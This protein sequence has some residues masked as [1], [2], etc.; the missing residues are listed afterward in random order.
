[1]SGFLSSGIVN[2]TAIP[3]SVVM[4]YYATTW[5]QGDATWVDG[6]NSD[7]SQDMSITGDVQANTLSDGSDALGFDGADDYGSTTLPSSLEG[8]SLN[9][10]SLEF[11]LAWDHTNTNYVAGLY[12]GTQQ[13]MVIL[14]K[15]GGGR[16]RFRLDDTNGSSYEFDTQTAI[17]DGNRHNVSFIINDASANDG[18]AIV[19]GSEVSLSTTTSTNPDS[20]TTWNYDFSWGAR[21]IQGSFQDNTDV[22]IGAI[23]FHDSAINNQTIS[24]YP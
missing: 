15:N 16:I 13:I 23:R 14:N 21:N 19:D 6:A 11:A 10:L 1:M 9:S 12:N 20:F 5:S 22:D 24:D 8:S 3:D 2:A 7:G 17:N 18:K 4:Q